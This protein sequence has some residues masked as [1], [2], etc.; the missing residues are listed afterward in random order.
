MYIFMIIFYSTSSNKQQIPS[1]L[2]VPLKKDA[3]A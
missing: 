1:G 2:R 3:Y